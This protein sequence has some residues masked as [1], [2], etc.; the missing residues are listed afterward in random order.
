MSLSQ[1]FSATSEQ[2][3][4]TKESGAP[5]ITKMAAK[6]L[7]INF[8]K[9]PQCTDHEKLHPPTQ[10]SRSSIA[11]VTKGSDASTYPKLSSA[12][13]K[14]H[15]RRD[16]KTSCV[17]ICPHETLSFER[18]KRIA[19]LPHFKDSGDNIDAFTKSPA[20]YHLSTMAGTHLCKPHPNDFSSLK[21]SGF[22]KYQRGDEGS[23]DGLMLCVCWTMSLAD[24]R[25]FAGS[26][27]GFQRFLDTLDIR[28][29]QH[30]K[31]SDSKIAVRVHRLCDP[32]R[33]PRDPVE[34]YEEGYRGC[35]TEKCKGCHT[36]SRIYRERKV[37]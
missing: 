1:C 5:S 3:S 6:M 19:H 18:M 35:I 22:Y 26:I 34:V 25:D 2:Y 30:T 17:Q 29:C 7:R 10:S 27:S 9:P 37:C 4:L 21:S 8:D 11:L 32:S 33:P 15:H 12:E 14:S 36:T 23:Y 20:P 13:E 31:M 16:M 24:T 28:L